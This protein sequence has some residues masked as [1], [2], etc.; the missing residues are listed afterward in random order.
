MNFAY[1][2]WD[3][4]PN[5]LHLGFLTIRWYGVLFAL[6]LSFGYLILKNMY[7]TEGKNVEDLERLSVYLIIGIVA[8]ARIGHVIFY[9]P[10]YYFTHPIEILKIWNGGLAS[11]GGIGNIICFVYL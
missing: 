7:K 10:E 6:A 1:I 8:G 5:I 2:A 4:N 3:I 11:H 9:Q